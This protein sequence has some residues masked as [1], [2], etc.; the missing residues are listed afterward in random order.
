MS[1]KI[2]VDSCCDTTEELR[3]Q[4]D[5][6]IA[7]LVI[8]IPGY[9]NIIDTVDN[10]TSLLLE[11]IASVKEPASTACPSVDSYVE[12]MKA[13]DET[14]VVTLSSNLSGSYNSACAARDLVLEKHPNKKIHILDS[15]SASAGEL[16]IVFFV[17]SLRKAG[18]GFSSII[19]KAEAFIHGFRTMF[20]LEDL[21]TLVKNGRM[22]KVKGI[23]AS[24]LG[25]RPICADNGAGEIVSLHAVRGLEQAFTKLIKVIGELTVT[26]PIRSL[27][28]VLSHCHN[29]E[30][31]DSL[32]TRILEK[33]PAIKEITVVPTSGLSTIYANKG[34]IVIAF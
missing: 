11:K 23:V 17:D 29:P 25:I 31:A 21:S 26:K 7:P 33:C 4:L 5:L 13:Q 1:V 2:I 28:M 12:L 18:E 14:I 19:A 9:K 10:D 8:S 34:G 20:V 6:S 27:Q 15:L 16:L 3:Q 22:S 32:K 24:V 30:R